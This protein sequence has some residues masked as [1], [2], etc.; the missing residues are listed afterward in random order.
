MKRNLIFYLYPRRGSIWSW[1]VDQL[2]QFRHAWNG[3][4]L[5][6]VA[7][8]HL[9]EHPTTVLQR[10]QPLGAEICW[11]QNDPNLGETAHL[12]HKLSLVSSLNEDEATFY[13]HAK[14]VTHGGHLLGAVMR[15]CEAMYTLN[16]GSIPAVE[17]SLSLFSAVGCF[18]HFL[19]HAGSRWCYGG[20]FFWLKHSTLFSRKWWDIEHSKY[21]V[22]GYPGRH[23]RWGELRT[24]TPDNVGPSWLYAGGVTHAY[25]EQWKQNWEAN[26][27]GSVIGYLKRVVAAKDVQG[28]DVLEVGSYNVNGT[29]RIVFMPY[30]P[31][32][33]VGVDQEAGPCVDRVVNATNLVT[34]L[35]KDSFDVVL[36]TEMLEHAKDWRAAVNNM[37]S[38]VK[39]GGTLFVTTRGPGFPFHG[40]PEDHWR[41][42]TEDF[43]KIFADMEIIDLG[44]DPEF[45]GVF[46]KA[47]KPLDWKAT[48]L[49]G[50]NLSPAPLP[51]TIHLPMP[52]AP[53]VGTVYVSA[54]TRMATGRGA[55]LSSGPSVKVALNSQASHVGVTAPVGHASNGPAQAYAGKP[56]GGPSSSPRNSPVTF[57][58][59][60]QKK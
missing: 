15:W 23:L 16:L 12:I 27:H 14:G 31:K 18:R 1:H 49:S 20:T 57:S 45:P 51:G 52:A 25:V 60:K 28:K 21:G 37:K 36:S 13:A 55:I 29:P 48:D 40:F 30:G 26:M 8:D 2:V 54:P 6:T 56:S 59:A 3:R 22:E 17:R 32:S 19:R 42:T 5:I 41:Y 38:I 50:I 35:G 39:P 4:K 46:M 11:V 43:R 24:F 9:T 53:S 33:Y 7:I 58:V 34:T 44:P 47:R 10:L